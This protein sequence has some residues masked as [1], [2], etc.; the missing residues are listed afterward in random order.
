MFGQT[1]KRSKK[2]YIMQT[3]EKLFYVS[4]IK[5]PS[6]VVIKRTNNILLFEGPLGFIELDTLKI[7][8]LG[9]GFFKINTNQLEIFVKKTSKSSKAFF[10]SLL[11]LCQNT[12]Y[13]VSQ[14]YLIYLELIG[15][16]FRA[17]VH[18]RDELGNPSSTGRSFSNEI[19]E[20]FVSQSLTPFSPE[21]VK[22]HGFV[23]SSEALDTSSSADAS[24]VIEFKIGQSHDIFYSIPE[25]IKVF[26]LKPTLFCLYG[27]EK[28]QITQLAAQIRSLKP[29]EPY[30]GK[31][32]RLRDEVVKIKIGKKK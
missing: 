32:I 31:G 13:G 22:P 21:R 28:Q 30:K 17:L 9:L 7:D 3:I 27:L 1:K 15:V 6:Q 2:K 5:I 18:T 19:G 24:Q 16:G 10:G 4:K 8:S 29:P 25:N 23:F 12:I 26:S 14:G 20:R 11:S